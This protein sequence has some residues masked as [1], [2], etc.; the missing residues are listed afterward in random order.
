MS[1]WVCQYILECVDGSAVQLSGYSI[2]A[3][4]IFLTGVLTL[5][6][7]ILEPGTDDTPTAL[8][9]LFSVVVTAI[10]TIV[11]AAIVVA[12]LNIHAGT[13]LVFSASILAIILIILSAIIKYK[14]WK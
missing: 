9:A 2:L 6:L 5:L 3:L 12:I 4:W 13:I 7:I 1:T 11:T 10:I 8:V 14:K